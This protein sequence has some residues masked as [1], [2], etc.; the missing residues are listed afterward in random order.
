MTISRF[1]SAAKCVLQFSSGYPVLGWLSTGF[2]SILLLP[3]HPCLPGPVSCRAG[4]VPC[5]AVPSDIAPGP[6]APPPAPLWSRRETCRRRLITPAP[7]RRWDRAGRPGRP[8][9]MTARRSGVVRREKVTTY[10]RTCSWISK[11][12]L[13]IWSRGSGFRCV[14]IIDLRFAVSGRFTEIIDPP[15]R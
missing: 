2:I 11:I 12:D 15:S 4:A 8:G 9:G 14:R 7:P 6:S 13:G 1:L 10:D 3:P 5:R